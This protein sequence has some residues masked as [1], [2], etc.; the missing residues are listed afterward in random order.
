GLN[1]IDRK[2]P[3]L[4]DSRVFSYLLHNYRPIASEGPFILLQSNFC[5]RASLT[6]LRGGTAQP[7]EHIDLH[8]QNEKQLWMEIH[9]EP[10]LLGRARH[11]FLKSPKLRL[12]LWPETAGRSLVKM[13]APAPML[14]SGFLI[15]PVF[16]NN[17]DV[18]S[19]YSNS[20]PIRPFTCSI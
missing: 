11:F 17:S 1:A 9:I 8:G 7:G 6:L 10:N 15:S 18:L 14:A 12:A 16:L 5:S 4:E 13:V 2:Y 20:P 3:P 19:Y